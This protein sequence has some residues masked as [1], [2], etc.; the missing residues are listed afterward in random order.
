MRKEEV[1]NQ[2]PKNG[3][4][5]ASGML[6]CMSGPLSTEGGRLVAMVPG[7]LFGHLTPMV[8]CESSRQSQ[9]VRKLC[10]LL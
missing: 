9:G 8:S 7:R 10:A 3:T 1:Q 4:K 2:K 5:K 6:I